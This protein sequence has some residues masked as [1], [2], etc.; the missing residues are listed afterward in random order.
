M[1]FPDHG[2]PSYQLVT[3]ANQVHSRTAA[4][5]TTANNTG[6]DQ[7]LRHSE[8]R[9]VSTKIAFPSPKREAI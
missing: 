9:V 2:E 1:L 7:F 5:A 4:N 8:H 3:T 6:I